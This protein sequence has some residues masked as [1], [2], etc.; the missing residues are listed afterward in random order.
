MGSYDH[1]LV[2]AISFTI[3]ALKDWNSKA[4]LFL[5]EEREPAV[6]FSQDFN[7]SNNYQVDPYHLTH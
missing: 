5:L 2:Y 3:F 4:T 7:F 1:S 6:S